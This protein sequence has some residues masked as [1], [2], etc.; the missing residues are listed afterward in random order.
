MMLFGIADGTLELR[1]TGSGGARLRGRFPYGKTAVLSDGGRTGRPRKE[2]IISR[3]F[4]YRIERADEEIHILSGHDY[5]KP[6]ASRGTK[7][8]GIRDSAEAVEFDAEISNEIASTSYGSDLLKQV[9]SGLVVGLSPGFR[10]PP[11][12]AVQHAEEIEQEP[13]D[14]ARGM[15]GALIRKVRQ[16]LLFEFSVVTSPAYPEA[17]VEMRSWNLTEADDDGVRRALNRWRR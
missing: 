4:G 5:S 17:Q 11:A 14:P 2:S 16:A 8:L 3:A 12:R 1:A 6:L 7:T 9:R 13:V 15:H 10:I